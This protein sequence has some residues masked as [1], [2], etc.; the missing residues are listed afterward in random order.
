MTNDGEALF[1]A[2]CEH[3]REL[4]PRLVY[5]DWL[6]EN[7]RPERGE[8]IR[9]QCAEWVP[10]PAYPTP[11]AARTRASELLRGF[12]DRWDAELPA[13]PWLEWGDMYVGGFVDTAR[14]FYLPDV[15]A[16]LELVFAATP[17][18]F[19]MID[20]LEPGQIRAVLTFPR[21]GRLSRLNLPGITGYEEARLLTD[22]RDR[23]P[24]TEFV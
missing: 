16:A 24:D 2:I 21:L 12:R 23:Y 8:F 17:L 7:G 3:P 19:L 15:R 1:R 14:A 6:T 9:A 5:A 18:R 13:A 10:C 22:A 11:A 20:G 4:T